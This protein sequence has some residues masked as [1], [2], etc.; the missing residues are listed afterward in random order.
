MLEVQSFLSS[1]SAESLLS[2]GE[3][4]A[5]L[6][7]QQVGPLVTQDNPTTT[8]HTRWE[9]SGSKSLCVFLP[10]G[11][12]RPGQGSKHLFESLLCLQRGNGGQE[13]C[14]GN[15]WWEIKIYGGPPCPFVTSCLS[16]IVLHTSIKQLIVFLSFRRPVEKRLFWL[17][18]SDLQL[19]VHSPGH[20]GTSQ[21]TI[22]VPGTD[23]F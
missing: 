16:P 5:E 15:H 14:S 11:C 17:L 2:L 18:S 19:P 4:R 8:I 9:R 22:N 6:L 23:R 12:V 1:P 3:K 7:E 20:D 10:G 21:G 13:S